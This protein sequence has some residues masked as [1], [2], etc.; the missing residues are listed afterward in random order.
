M[1][2]L[3]GWQFFLVLMGVLIYGDFVRWLRKRVGETG[4]WRY[5]ATTATIALLIVILV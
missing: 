2:T 3:A 4:Y 1:I 5:V